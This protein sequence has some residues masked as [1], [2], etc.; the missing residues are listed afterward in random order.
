[1]LK[2]K[3]RPGSTMKHQNLTQAQLDQMVPV[4]LMLALKLVCYVSA[5]I[6]GS[7]YFIVVCFIGNLIH[8]CVFFDYWKF[9]SGFTSRPALRLHTWMCTGLG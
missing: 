5:A 9:R 6:C 4:V 3:M 7:I 2:L 8:G 1:M